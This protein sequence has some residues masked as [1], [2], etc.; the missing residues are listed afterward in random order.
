MK[1]YVAVLVD[2]SESYYIGHGSTIKM[3]GAWKTHPTN[4]VVIK[5]SGLKGKYVDEFFKTNKKNDEM[6]L[7]GVFIGEGYKIILSEMNVE[8]TFYGR[9][10]KKEKK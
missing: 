5:K 9:I 10:T 8:N 3:I 7:D 1:V 2:D 6:E 4:K